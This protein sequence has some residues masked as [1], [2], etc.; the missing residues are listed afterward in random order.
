MT[1][2]CVFSVAALAALTAVAAIAA[3]QAKESAFRIDIDPA[4]GVIKD[5]R[6]STCSPN[7]G[8]AC[9]LDGGV[10]ADGYLAYVK[11]REK[12]ARIYREAGVWLVRPMSM[13]D[14]W[15]GIAE[16]PGTNFVFDAKGKC[17]W[18]HPK[19]LFSFYREYDIKAIVCLNAWAT[20]WKGDLVGLLKWIVDNGYAGTV[21]GFEMCNEPFYGKDPEGYAACWKELLKAIRAVMPDVKIGL[22]LAEYCPG[23]PDIAAAKARLLG[24]GNL[25]AD[26]FKAN[27]LNRWSA[28]VVE[29]LGKELTNVTHVIYHVYGAE[30]AYGC[31][32]AGFHRFR[33]FAKM[34]PQVADKRWW[35]TEWRERSDE[36]LLCQRQFRQVLWKAMY[37]QTA[38]CQPELDGFTLHELTSLSGA[39]YFNAH[40]KWNQYFDNWQNHGDR[41]RISD[42]DYRYELGGTGALFG[43]YTHALR[44]HPLVIDWGTMKHSMRNPGKKGGRV[45]DA[46]AC[47]AY[48]CDPENKGD[49]Q[50]TALMNPQR[51]SLCLLLANATDQD[52]VVPLS[53]YGHILKTK[54]YRYV[55]CE[56]RYLSAREV[57]GEA[58]PWRQVSWEDVHSAGATAPNTLTIPPFSVGTAMITFGKWGDWL[59]VHIGR[60]MV[61]KAIAENKGA[62]VECCGIR[63]GKVYMPLP[64]GYPNHPEIK[65]NLPARKACLVIGKDPKKLNLAAVEK[66]R[67]AGFHVH[68]NE[69]ENTAWLFRAKGM[70]E[71]KS[72]ELEARLR[73]MAGL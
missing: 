57:P 67:K 68:L 3:D 24:E 59:A 48:Y 19:Y 5:L 18:L 64:D 16:H 25:S 54:T 69:A 27:N 50:W 36:D 6:E 1:R 4:N 21:T 42:D 40:G 23:D 56:K 34:F 10:F 37:A 44:S 38:L 2:R 30:P 9:D 46:Y 33:N 62:T 43:L 20:K 8:Y 17:T 51:N 29:S 63:A 52:L 72:A 7:V 35:I 66:V 58:K 26:Y 49:C 22:P 45:G 53:V 70:D 14:L 31:S 61:N 13:L 12:T 39:F 15:H 11:H 65:E 47:S 71:K 32:P 73:E 55:T 28:R 60:P 41:L